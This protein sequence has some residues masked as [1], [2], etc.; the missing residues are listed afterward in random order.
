VV[1]SI[2]NS[3][4]HDYSSLECD[5]SDAFTSIGM[6]FDHIFPRD[7]YS[8]RNLSNCLPPSALHKITQGMD[9][10][11]LLPI[12]KC[13]DISDQFCFHFGRSGFEKT[14]DLIASVQ[15]ATGLKPIRLEKWLNIDREN[16]ASEFAEMHRE[17]SESRFVLTDTYHVCVNSMALGIPVYCIG[18]SSKKQIGTLGDFKKKILFEMMNANEFYFEC[19]QSEEQDG[20]L[21]RVNQVM[22]EG[23]HD[24]QALTSKMHAHMQRMVLDF[25]QKVNVAI[26]G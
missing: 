1:I 6:N 20:F 23:L 9:C 13:D 17:I 15:N 21:E 26:F 4:Q 12:I 22:R 3:F 10:A 25:R 5:F 24:E 16:A 14:Q 8:R 18:R 2:G 11:F 7:P 19:G